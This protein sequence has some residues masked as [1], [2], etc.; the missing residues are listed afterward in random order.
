M[1]KSRS[2]I[3][4]SY[5]RPQDVP[6][7]KLILFQVG[8]IRK[9]SMRTFDATSMVTSKN[10]IKHELLNIAVLQEIQ[11]L[12]KRPESLSGFPVFSSNMRLN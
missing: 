3:Q 4:I 7:L 11:M 6:L 5:F 9:K 8:P 12:Q 10:N 1:V 2:A